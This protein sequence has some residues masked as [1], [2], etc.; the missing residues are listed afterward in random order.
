TARSAG[1]GP[2]RRGPGAV[3]WTG[4]AAAL[5]AAAW[6]WSQTPALEGRPEARSVTFTI[7]APAGT[8]FREGR[9][10]PDGRW[11]AFIG[12]E[13]GGSKRLWV[14]RLDSLTARPIARAEGTPI[15]SP[16]SRY[17]AFWDEEKLKKIGVSGGYPQVICNA[18][19]VIGGSWGPD[20]HIIFS[21]FAEH[22]GPQILM[23]AAMGGE[24]KSLTRLDAKRGENEHNFPVFL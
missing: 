11:L 6:T 1:G 13:T 3:W 10:S 8:F 9:V 2:G 19:L 12:Y 22:N 7:E 14:R 21:G 17:V 4:W 23:V 24:A 20:G 16:D 18:A 5:A 15:W